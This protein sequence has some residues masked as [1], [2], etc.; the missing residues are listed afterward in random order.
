[1]GSYEI[2]MEE[3]ELNKVRVFAKLFVQVCLSSLQAPGVQ[4]CEH[5]LFRAGSKIDM[6]LAKYVP[7]GKKYLNLVRIPRGLLIFEEINN[8]MLPS[9]L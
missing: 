6:F 4:H 7:V 9:W 3:S 2:C 8:M 5:N 1:M